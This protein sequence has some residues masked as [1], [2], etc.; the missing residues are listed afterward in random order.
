MIYNDKIAILAAKVQKYCEYAANKQAVFATLR[1]FLYNC[2]NFS[3]I[4]A[5]RHLHPDT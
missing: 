1:I 2:R 3:R 4:P 5:V